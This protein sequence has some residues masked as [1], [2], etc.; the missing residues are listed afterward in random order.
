MA[1]KN[2]SS[3]W[4]VII[5]I[6]TILSLVVLASTI[7]ISVVT[8]PDTL[9]NAK[10]AAIDSG[11]TAGEAELAASIALGAFIAAL[12]FASA[13]D[14]LKI[15]GGFMF[16][17]KGRWGIFCII[18]SIMSAVGGFWNLINDITNKSPI[19]NIIVAIA[20]LAI[21]VVLVI[22]CFKHYAE[23]K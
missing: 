12:V 13:F 17:L 10:Q 22:A 16:S 18:V 1:N 11:A 2:K 3:I 7:A 19:A 4:A 21:N 14:V 6:A 23:N 5:L 8:L 15:I 20:G 9:A